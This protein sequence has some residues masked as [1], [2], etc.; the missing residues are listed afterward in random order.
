MTL[1]PTSP[2]DRRSLA[3]DRAAAWLLPAT[4]LA[5]ALPTLMAY[6]QPPSATLLNQCLAVA[7]WGAVVALLAWVA[8]LRPGRAALPLLAALALLAAAAF[9]SWRWGTLPRSLAAQPLGLLVAAILSFSLQFAS[10]WL[11]PRRRRCSPT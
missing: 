8:P 4:L 11:S 6:H 1:P 7:L 5:A 9:A 10:P 3:S 2:P